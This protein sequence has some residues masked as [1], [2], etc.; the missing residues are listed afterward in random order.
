MQHPLTAE[1]VLDEF[2]PRGVRFGTPAWEAQLT[3]AGQNRNGPKVGPLE[4]YLT[5]VPQNV[6]SAEKYKWQKMLLKICIF[7]KHY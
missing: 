1:Q 7:Q 4:K 6:K 3:T 2:F 5:C